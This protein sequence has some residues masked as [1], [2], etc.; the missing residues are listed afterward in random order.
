MVLLIMVAGCAELAD[1][2]KRSGGEASSSNCVGCH[3][4]EDMLKAVAEPDTS[5]GDDPGEG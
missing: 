3:T 5:E 1:P 2:L 4:D